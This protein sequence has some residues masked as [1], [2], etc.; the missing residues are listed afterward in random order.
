MAEVVVLDV[1]NLRHLRLPALRI[2][3]DAR[4][5]AWPA[6]IAF[7]DGARPVRVRLGVKPLRWPSS[8][9]E[10]EVAKLPIVEL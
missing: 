1:G 10:A 9:L 8:P 2:L 7:E 5:D 4:D 6:A 3:Q